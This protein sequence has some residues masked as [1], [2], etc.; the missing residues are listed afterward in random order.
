MVKKILTNE[1]LATKLYNRIIESK[2]HSRYCQCRGCELR[3]GLVDQ[4]ILVQ[5]SQQIN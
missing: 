1:Q 4:P 3:K 5:G 2:D